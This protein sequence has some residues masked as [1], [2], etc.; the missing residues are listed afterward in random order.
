[1]GSQTVF[2]C[3]WWDR[4]KCVFLSNFR[5]NMPMNELSILSQDTTPEGFIVNDEAQNEMIWIGRAAHLN[6]DFKIF[7]RTFFFLG[8]S[9]EN[10][11]KPRVQSTTS[12]PGVNN[13]PKDPLASLLSLNSSLSGSYGGSGLGSSRSVDSSISQSSIPSTS[14]GRLM[15]NSTSWWWFCWPK[16]NAGCAKSAFYTV[17]AAV[18]ACIL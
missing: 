1:M 13:L 8:H 7:Q 17:L 6:H 12:I 15:L 5:C 3:R 10:V 16:K 11:G 14:R 4:W 9:D 2:W 18:C